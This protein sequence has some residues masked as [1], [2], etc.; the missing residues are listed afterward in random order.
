MRKSDGIPILQWY[1]KRNS[2]QVVCEG[3]DQDHESTANAEQM[4]RKADRGIRKANVCEVDPAF[5]ALSLPTQVIAHL[6][7]PHIYV[8]V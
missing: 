7:C 4:Q 6:T 1:G 3:G 2:L 5:F 8:F